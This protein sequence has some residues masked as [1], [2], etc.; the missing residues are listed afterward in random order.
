MSWL[1][2]DI[3]HVF[4]A[5]AHAT[6]DT[7]IFKF[8]A[9]ALQ[10]S[11]ASLYYISTPD[12]ADFSMGGINSFCVDFWVYP[13]VLPIT[14]QNRTFCGHGRSGTSSPNMA[15]WEFYLH[16]ETQGLVW[17][18]YDE[19]GNLVHTANTGEAGAGLTINNWQHLAMCANKN[20]AN[21][22]F[23]FFKDGT[24]VGVT[25]TEASVALDDPKGLFKI[26]AS[27]SLNNLYCKIDEFRFSIGTARWTENFTPPV[28]PYTLDAYTKILMHFGDNPTFFL[29]F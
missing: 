20:G 9:G 23:R 8:P 13:I 18:D 17:I 6:Q 26:G 3:G 15:R 19:A 24:Q 10:F 25:D 2:D 4:T 22:D 14:D 29:L 12:S 11:D 1:N 7:T 27:L 21:L 16:Y 28:Y 5:E